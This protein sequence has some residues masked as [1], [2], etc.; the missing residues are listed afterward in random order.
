MHNRNLQ[1]LATEMF[2]VDNNI[3]SPIFTEIFNDRNLNYQL[4]HILHFSILSVRS[5][6]N[7]TESL[8]FLGP[9]IWNIV[10]TELKEVTFLNQELRIGGHKTFH[11]GYISHI[12]QILVL[13]NDDPYAW[14]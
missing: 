11:A 7:G 2:K 1:I 12:S 14:W 9:N 13:Y 6:Y 10:P 3:A 8:S 5:V 4:R